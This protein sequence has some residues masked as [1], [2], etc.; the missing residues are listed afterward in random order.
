[1]LLSPAATSTKVWDAHEGAWEEAPSLP[2]LGPCQLQPVE[3]ECLMG[4]TGLR[5]SRPTWAAPPP[6]PAWPPPTQQFREGG[7]LWRQV[8]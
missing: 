4:R 3:P 6:H 1:M 7:G 8:L 5:A 2:R